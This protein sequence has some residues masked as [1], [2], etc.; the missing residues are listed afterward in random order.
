MRNLTVK[1]A[2]SIVGCLAKI[3]IY[4]ED[5]NAGEI[6]INNTPC[7]KIGELKNGEEKTF[8]I[9]NQVLKVFAIADAASKNFCF[10]YVELSEGEQDIFLSGKTFSTLR[11]EMHLYLMAT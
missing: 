10:D 4:I 9:E 1:R 7:R 5:P 8:A 6:N 2:K 11:Q 3:K